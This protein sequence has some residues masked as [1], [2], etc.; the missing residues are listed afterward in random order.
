M[1]V[2]S[3]ARPAD[4]SSS[5]TLSVFDGYESLAWYHFSKAWYSPIVSAT[6]EVSSYAPPLATLLSVRVRRPA[7][8][9]K[10]ALVEFCGLFTSPTI[11]G[12]TGEPSGC[13]ASN[14]RTPGHSAPGIVTSASSESHL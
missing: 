9:P 10:T 14:T 8:N 1:Y 6:P 2:P 4:A 11:V 12:D 7:P 3:F 13:A 5:A